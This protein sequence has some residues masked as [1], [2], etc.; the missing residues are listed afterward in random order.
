MTREEYDQIAQDQSSSVQ[1]DILMFCVNQSI[2][3]ERERCAK[4]AEDNTNWTFPNPGEYVAA[5]IR[6]GEI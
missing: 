3:D 1:Y 4:I 5:K 2:F 6:S